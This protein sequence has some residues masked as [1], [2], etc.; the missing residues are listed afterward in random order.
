M[1]IEK[2]RFTVQSYVILSL[3]FMSSVVVHA[4][5]IG[6]ALDNGDGTFT[7]SYTVDNSS[8]IFDIEAWSLE[9]FITPDWNQDDIF[10]GGDVGVPTDWFALAG[11]PTTGIA[12]QDFVSF[13]GAEVF[14]GDTPLG[15]FTFTSSSQ[16]GTITFF[17]FGPGGA[18]TSGTTIG[19][20]AIPEPGTLLLFTA[21]LAGLLVS[22]RFRKKTSVR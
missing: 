8:G 7:Y 1:K 15:G 17:E 22:Y 18:S 12:A 3:L 19:P 11:I 2:R 6:S 20:A 13:P 21:T 16:P 5:I 10:A 14:V 9:F 4:T